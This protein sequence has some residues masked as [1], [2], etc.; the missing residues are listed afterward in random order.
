MLAYCRYLLCVCVCVCVD[1]IRLNVSEEIK[2]LN[3]STQ[4]VQE[5]KVLIETSQFVMQSKFLQLCAA[6]KEIECDQFCD[7]W[8][9]HSQ[10]MR[11]IFEVTV[12]LTNHIFSRLCNQKMEDKSSLL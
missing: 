5:C 9:H 10:V 3:W 2:T 1:L 12:K 11:D 6:R 7:E 8:Q 4:F